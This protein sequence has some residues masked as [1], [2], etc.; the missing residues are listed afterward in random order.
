M[1]KECKM[2]RGAQKW[3]SGAGIQS[4][5]LLEREKRFTFREK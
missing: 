5:K 4:Q 1:H 2:A 3:G